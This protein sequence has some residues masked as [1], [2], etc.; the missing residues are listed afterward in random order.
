MILDRMMRRQAKR[1]PHKL[2]MK[3]ILPGK[4]TYIGLAVSLAGLIGSRFGLVIPENEI[5]G[6]V[7]F[8]AANWDI[9]AQLGGLLTAAYGRLRVNWQTAPKPEI[10]K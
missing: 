8:V 1:N 5:N 7:S 6:I 4:L 9:F 2:T 3:T 10:V